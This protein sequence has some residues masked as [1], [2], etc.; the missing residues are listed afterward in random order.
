MDTGKKLANVCVPFQL[1][2]SV[3][4]LGLE[5]RIHLET[6]VLDFGEL[7][8]YWRHFVGPQTARR[9][10]FEFFL[11]VVCLVCLLF[12]S[13]NV[14][15]IDADRDTGVEV[16]AKSGETVKARWLITCAGLHSDYVGHMAGGP[17][18][19]TVLP[20]RGTYHELKPEYRHIVSRNI[21]PV[22][23]PKCVAK[24]TELSCF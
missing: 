8:F 19:P 7:D 4:S 10:D 14:R 9:I 15:G 16:H 2:F 11:H 20:F 6:M 1:R 3:V 12:C 21:Y 13:F 17:K 5:L 24:P 23:D 18:G 22:P